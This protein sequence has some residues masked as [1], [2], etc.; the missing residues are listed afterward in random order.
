M[1]T[2][3]DSLP[4]YV[5]KGV[6]ANRNMRFTFTLTGLEVYDLLQFLEHLAVQGKNAGDYDFVRSCVLWAEKFREQAKQQ[7]F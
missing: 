5:S 3:A 7:G 6:K 2:V 1:A 4:Y